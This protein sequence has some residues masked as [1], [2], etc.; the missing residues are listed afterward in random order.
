[1]PAVCS[2][3]S[4][5]PSLHFSHSSQ[6]GAALFMVASWAGV[7]GTL[8]LGGTL[9]P[10]G[11]N[12]DFPPH[13]EPAPGLPPEFIL[14]VGPTR[15]TPPPSTWMKQPPTLTVMSEPA[16]ST[17]LAP[18]LTCTSCPACVSQLSP[19]FWCMEVS[20][21]SEWSALM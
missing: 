12:G 16:S 14:M 2:Q 7:S 20:T 18:A 9:T 5:P 4:Q 21:P 1:L 13:P 19:S 10:R 17:T 15:V 8:G 3:I 6:K 11:P